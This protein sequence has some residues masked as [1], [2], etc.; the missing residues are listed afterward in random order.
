MSFGGKGRKAELYCKRVANT[1]NPKRPDI[2]ILKTNSRV[3]P[4]VYYGLKIGIQLFY[5][6]SCVAELM[7]EAFNACLSPMITKFN[8]SCKGI[9][10]I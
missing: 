7:I 10:P 8:E 6:L 1:S 9:L 2:P 5:N 4:L 3:K